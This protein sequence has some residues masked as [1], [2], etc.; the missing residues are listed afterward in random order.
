[1]KA[2]G[3]TPDDVRGMRGENGTLDPEDVIAAK[4]TG[5][6]PAYLN[7]M[8]ALFPNADMDDLIGASA[9]GIDTGYAREMK[10]WFPRVTID[11][12]SGM[13]AVG[14]TGAFVRDMRKSG[15]RVSTPDDAIELRATSGIN[16]SQVVSHAVSNATRSSSVSVSRDGVAVVDMRGPDGA[17]M[18]VET[19]QPPGPPQPP[20]T[21]D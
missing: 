9:L 4:A 8:R 12:L 17:T 10:S 18:R 2:M 21:N 20:A 19:P 14:V 13:R 11:D 1:M 5:A 7:R 6:S 15:V 3:I 16:I